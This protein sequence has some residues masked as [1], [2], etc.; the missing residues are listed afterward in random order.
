MT[1]GAAMNKANQPS[2]ATHVLEGTFYFDPD[3]AIYRD[4][5]PGNPVVPGSLIVHAFLE[6]ATS[7]GWV[8]G[9]CRL[10]GF[11]FSRFVSPGKTHFRMEFREG[12]ILDCK[13]HSQGHLSATGRIRP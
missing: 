11:R 6:T 1:W 2:N 4:H 5:F 3:D 13:L 8:K 12:K 10:E 9:N 7:Q